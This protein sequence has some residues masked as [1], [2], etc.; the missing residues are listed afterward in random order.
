MAWA[1][2]RK[3]ARLTPVR[4]AIEPLGHHRLFSRRQLTVSVGEQRLPQRYG[5]S[6]QTRGGGPLSGYIH[7]P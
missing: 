7:R 1:G 6:G 3:N 4:Q 2:R 5:A